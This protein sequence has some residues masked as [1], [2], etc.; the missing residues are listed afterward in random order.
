MYAGVK[1]TGDPASPEA[2]ACIDDGAPTLLDGFV[3]GSCII[4]FDMFLRP[5]HDRHVMQDP[6]GETTTES[7]RVTSGGK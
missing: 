6:N 1:L 3:D 7:I 4:D 5:N 2:P